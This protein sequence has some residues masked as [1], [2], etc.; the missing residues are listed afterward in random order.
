LQEDHPEIS[1]YLFSLTSSASTSAPAP[2]TDGPSNLAI[3]NY[4][5]LQTSHLL[6]EA[7]QLMAQAAERGEE[8]DENALREVVERAVRDGIAWSGGDAAA[9]SEQAEDSKRRRES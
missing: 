6:A 2:Q 5:D 3:E 9:E 7:Q 4:A 8:V 1:Q